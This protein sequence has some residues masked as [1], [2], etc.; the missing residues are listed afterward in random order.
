MIE[1]VGPKLV[2]RLASINH[3]VSEKLSFVLQAISGES[4]AETEP[5]QIEISEWYDAQMALLWNAA[6]DGP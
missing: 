6:E 5:D 3:P 4:E 1:A 2:A